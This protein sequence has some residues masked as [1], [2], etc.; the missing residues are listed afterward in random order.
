MKKALSLILGAMMLTSVVTGCS[1]AAPAA[2]STAGAS[3]DVPNVIGDTSKDPVTISVLT[4]NG[5]SLHYDWENMTWWN[6]VLKRANVKLDMEMLDSSTYAD[7]VKPRLAAGTDLP[8]LVN[9]PGND[10]DLA[11]VNAGLFTDLTDF[12][13][14]RGVNIKTQFAN[15]DGLE[16][17]LRT[18]DGKIYYMPY[19]LTQDSNMRCVM[20]NTEW[21]EAVGMKVEDIKTIDDYTAFLRACKGVDMNG[22]G[23]DDEV[24][25]FSRSGM[26]GLWGIH[27]GLDLNDGGGYQLGEDGKVFCTFTSDA[28]KDF[29]TWAHDMY[30]EGL[31]Y[32]EFMTANYDVQQAL[33]SNRQA[34]SVM[35]FISNCTGYSQTF[36]P[37]WKFNEDACIMK[38]IVLEGPT[39]IKACYGRGSF[40]G[41]FGISSTCEKPETVFD[42]CDYLQSEEVGKLTWYGIEGVD[43]TVENGVEVFSQTYLDNKDNYLTNMGYNASHL[44]SFQLDYMTKQCD[45]VR[46][47]AKDLAPYVIN[48]SVT[49]SYKTAEQNDVI[50]TYA[51]DLKTYFDENLTAFITGTRSLSEWDAY[52]KTAKDMGVDEMVAMHQQTFDRLA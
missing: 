52:I 48:P 51:A 49:F 45:E 28:Y 29:L 12:V 47:A 32:N 4:T 35:H 41:A 14:K 5:A 8:E 34:G 15:F 7:S 25:M 2:S 18:P 42:F 43:Y 38:P 50:S 26:I 10:S 37:D 39:G 9:V 33:Y 16:T 13:E 27:W 3:N 30:A 17:S 6:E 31:L 21:V 23:Q 22:N 40:G 44:P 11:Y 19:I 24:P 1:G 36:N 46:Q 20:I